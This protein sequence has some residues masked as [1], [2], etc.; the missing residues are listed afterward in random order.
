M[1]PMQNSAEFSLNGTMSS[2]FKSFAWRTL[3]FLRRTLDFRMR[4]LDKDSFRKQISLA[5]SCRYRK[6][7]KI[8]IFNCS[9]LSLG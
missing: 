5:F 6:A 8:H 3:D 4:V 1:S 9:W 2:R 7:N